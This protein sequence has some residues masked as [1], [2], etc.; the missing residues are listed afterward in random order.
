MIWG[1][2][3]ADAA[4]RQIDDCEV[5][6]GAGF[7]W[8][9]L[10]LAS[11][12]SKDWIAAQAEL[13]GA[14]RELL[15]SPDTHQRALVDGGVV[16]CVLHDLERDF[17]DD[18]SVNVGALRV[19]FTD[20]M[21][22]TARLHPLRSADLVRSRLTRGATVSEPAQAL[23][24]LLAAIAE[25]VGGMARQLSVEMQRAEDKF[26]AGHQPPSPRD[27][28]LIRRRLAEL[29]RMLD[30]MHAVFRRL[31]VDDELPQT[32]L[33]T[34]EKI[35][36]RLRGLD[37]DVLAIQGQLRLLRDELEGQAAQRTNQNLYILSITTALL[38]PATLVTGIFGMN[39]GGMPLAQAGHGTLV[40]TM[41]ALGA[42]AATYLLLR[43]SGFTRR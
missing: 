38:L 19:A 28:M 6:A 42:A 1:L 29:H 37:G 40:A 32:V 33:P 2:A 17:D 13:P 15:L 8:L 9:H 35:S 24:L 27:L 23:D 30:C 34:V 4:M 3:Y 26:I 43:W 12:P 10:N 31:E 11:Q 14:V 36:Q 22:I 41:I 16:G 25:V 39:T 18:D 5:D 7:R 21:M 20:R